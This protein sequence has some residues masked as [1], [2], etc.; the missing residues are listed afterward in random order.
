MSTKAF[1]EYKTAR[2]RQVTRNDARVIRTKVQNAQQNPGAGD[3]WP[4]ELLQNAHD[5]GPRVGDNTVDVNFELQE[6]T[7]TVN[8]T[9]QPFTLQELAA[10]LTGGSS[11]QFDD[12]D[13]TGRFGTG[14]L[15][16]HALSPN[17]DI[18]GIFST[19]T[20][21]ER[22]DINLSRGGDEEAIE[23]NIYTADKSLRE[24]TSVT[25]QWVKQNPTVT[26]VYHAVDVQIA[27]TGLNQL[28]LVIPY[29]YGTCRQLGR[30]CINNNGSVT[31]YYCDAARAKSIDGS[32]LE[33]YTV[34]IESEDRTQ[35]LLVNRIGPEG[36][37]SALLT[38]L[39]TNRNRLT[40]TPCAS[41]FP[42][43]FIKFPVAETSFL[44]FNFVI[45][46]PFVPKQ[47]RDGIL[48]NR[49]DNRDNICSALSSLPAL[50]Q[51][52]F[53]MG[54]DNSH[55]LAQLGVP[56]RTLS[57]VDDQSEKEWWKEIILQVTESV[58]SKPIIMT[59][60]GRM[61]AIHN[62]ESAAAS[63]LV[64]GV[65]TLHK[66][67]IPYT[68]IHHLASNI[69]GLHIPDEATAQDWSSIAKD[70]A[71]SGVAVERLGFADLALIV[72]GRCT[73][74]ENLPIRAM[75]RT[76]LSR[77]GA[78]FSDRAMPPA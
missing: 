7:L 33:S 14:F 68:D 8:H 59:Q 11:K 62:S 37:Q 3:R 18:N 32:L 21:C 10:L 6:H 40:F 42:K 43:L 78:F 12:E 50:V 45:D 25:H 34:K 39:S 41:N 56:G 75:V 47:E 9:G 2:T 67:Q 58:A 69:E 16:T 44:P 17:V 77:L 54:W 57:G 46:G 66:E 52:G 22:F 48:M 72:K 38:T 29:L 26:F 35:D 51:H 27:S 30:V 70:W 31:S 20:G 64:P 60:S 23:E 15:V 49:D 19:G 61:P 73:R 74:L 63:F 55:M 71:S 53:D 24:A 4:F 28:N 13:T 5:A 1:E 65:D 36:S 76:V